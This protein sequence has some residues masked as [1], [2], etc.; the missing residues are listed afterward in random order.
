MKRV[1]HVVGAMNRGGVETWLMHL[2]RNM[3]RSRCAMD[4]LVHSMEPGEFDE[5]VRSLGAEIH[6]SGK[7]Q[8]VW[9]YGPEFI[10]LLRERGPYDVIHSHVHHFSGLTLGLARRAGV[11]IRIAHSHNDPRARESMRGAVRGGYLGTMKALIRRFST[12]GL[13][14]STS[15]AEALFGMDWENDNRWQVL[16]YGLDFT[17]F[18][19]IDNRDL[20]R[21]ELGIPTDAFVVGH[22]GSFTYQ[23][24]HAFLLEIAQKLISRRPDTWLLL[25]GDGPLRDT[26]AQRARDLGIAS[27]VIFAGVRS[28]VPRLM[29][30]AMDAFLFPSHFE[31]LGLVLVEAQAAGLPSVFSHV[32]PEEVDIVGFLLNRVS[33]TQSSDR[34]ADAVLA[35]SGRERDSMRISA[36]QK[37]DRSSFTID[38]SIAHLAQVYGV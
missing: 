11:P 2:L 13:A 20:C 15:A 12:H 16:K 30:N 7:P 27:Q 1:L 33:L 4:F 31:G 24:N 10:R 37:L 8:R 9:S 5:E 6:Y 18:R 26:V 21:Q 28:D 35:L 38:A 23:K 32:V 3:D 29:M 17:P 14:C 34:W 22:V 36:L 25:V 19:S